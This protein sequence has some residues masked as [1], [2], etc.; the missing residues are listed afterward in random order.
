MQDNMN[1][2]SSVRFNRKSPSII[3]WLEY[4]YNYSDFVQE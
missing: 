4:S 3:I 1:P 2:E